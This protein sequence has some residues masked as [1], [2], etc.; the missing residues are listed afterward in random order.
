MIWIPRKPKCAVPAWRRWIHLPP[1]PF[2]KNPS[3]IARMDSC[4]KWAARDSEPLADNEPC[5]AIPLNP[6]HLN[7]PFSRTRIPEQREGRFI[8]TSSIVAHAAECDPLLIQPWMA[9][10][11]AEVP[12]SAAK[13]SH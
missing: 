3:D 12:G 9:L 6:A 11:P 2:D 7:L 10:I 5:T 8:R 4:I 1:R 13:T